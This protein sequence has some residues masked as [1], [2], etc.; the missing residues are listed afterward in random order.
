MC[1][2][3]PGLALQ[4]VDYGVPESQILGIRYGFR[5]FYDRKH[6]PLVLTRRRVSRAGA[7]QPAGGAVRTHPCP[8]AAARLLLLLAGTSLTPQCSDSPSALSSCTLTL[9]CSAL[10]CSALPCPPPCR[11]RMVEEIHLEG[12]TI[13]G[14]SR[15]LPNVSEIVK[16]LGGWLGG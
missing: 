4:A 16:R 8:G 2:A 10:P 6:K 7:R 5:G 9:P 12:G 13:L 15:G 3:P 14:T 11:C 1:L